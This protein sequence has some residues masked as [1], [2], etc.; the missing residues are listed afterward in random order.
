MYATDAV[1]I[2]FA[3]IY[4]MVFGGGMSTSLLS[5]PPPLP[6]PP[7]EIVRI[8]ECDAV[9]A[10]LFTVLYVI[11]DNK[12]FKLISVWARR[13]LVE[14]GEKGTNAPSCVEL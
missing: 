7:I 6:P 2:S 5:P 3:L 13:S 9:L 8:S 11:F 1:F 12:S 4:W 14:C 10:C